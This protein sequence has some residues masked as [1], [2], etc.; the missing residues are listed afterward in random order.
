MIQTAAMAFKTIK[1]E[2][3]LAH[4][5]HTDFGSRVP[6]FKSQWEDSLVMCNIFFIYVMEGSDF[7]RGFLKLH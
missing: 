5:K 2:V 3:S 6:W 7:V 4:W 1:Q